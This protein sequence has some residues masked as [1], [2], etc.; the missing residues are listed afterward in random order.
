MIAEYQQRLGFTAVLISHEIPDVFYFSQRIAM[1][2][3]GRIIYAGTPNE[4]QRLSDPVVHEFIQG[5]ENRRPTIYR[6][7]FMTGPGSRIS[8]RKWRGCSVTRC[9]LR[10]SF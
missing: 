5:F 6:I 7:P 3:E 4:L 2:H 9:R 10:W 8:M 1:L